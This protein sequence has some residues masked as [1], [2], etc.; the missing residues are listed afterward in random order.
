MD[1]FDMPPILARL[2]TPLLAPVVAHIYQE[3]LSFDQSELDEVT[4]SLRE[5]CDLIAHMTNLAPSFPEAFKQTEV[6]WVDF[7][8]SMSVTNNSISLAER[9]LDNCFD[10]REVMEA[11]DQLENVL[12]PDLVLKI[13]QGLDPLKKILKKINSFIQFA[14]MFTKEH[15]RYAFLLSQSEFPDEFWKMCYVA[16]PDFFLTELPLLEAVDHVHVTVCNKKGVRCGEVSADISIAEATLYDVVEIAF[17]AF[18]DFVK[19]DQSWDASIYDVSINSQRP[20]VLDVTL[21]LC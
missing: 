7:L 21:R 9:D 8:A 16:S 4:L 3:R 14:T 12:H 5:L 11:K 10:Y 13:E 19:H 6:L 18:K 20:N 1:K 15:F 2:S 17:S